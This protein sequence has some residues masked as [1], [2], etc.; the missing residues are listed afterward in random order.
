MTIS[1][2]LT[3]MTRKSRFHAGHTLNERASPK[4]KG[5]HG[6]VTSRPGSAYAASKEEHDRHYFNWSFPRSVAVGS[7]TC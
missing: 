6:G 3:T 1:L 7:V 2:V 4:G 5:A